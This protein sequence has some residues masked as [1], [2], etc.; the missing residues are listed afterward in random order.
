M[1]GRMGKRWKEGRGRDGRRDGE[2]MEI[3]GRDGEGREEIEGGVGTRW[4]EEEKRG[5]EGGRWASRE[6]QGGRERK[7]YFR[8][9]YAIFSRHLSLLSFLLVAIL[10]VIS[11][12]ARPVLRI[13]CIK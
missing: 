9:S 2:E 8:I 11:R 12:L 10:T 6:G 3:W 13:H 7:R 5:K 1:E 4:R